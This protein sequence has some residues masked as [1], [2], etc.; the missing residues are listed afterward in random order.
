[1][2]VRTASGGLINSERRKH[3]DWAQKRHYTV[4]VVVRCD[5]TPLQVV[6]VSRIQRRPWPEMTERV[7]ALLDEFPGP[8][9]H[10]A[11][12]AGSAIGACAARC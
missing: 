5:T 7:G 4:A 3:L 2:V 6:A 10:D 11:T 8:A 1:M 9:V 12:G